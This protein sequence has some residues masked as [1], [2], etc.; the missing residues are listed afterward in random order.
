MGMNDHAQL[1]TAM[2]VLFFTAIALVWG[3]LYLERA[4]TTR[5]QATL[6]IGKRISQSSPIAVSGLRGEA[7]NISSALS[8]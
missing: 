2:L 7:A 3:Q 6:Q 1:A 5:E 8:R 4:T